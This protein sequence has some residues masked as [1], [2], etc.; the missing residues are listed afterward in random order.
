MKRAVTFIGGD[1]TLVA[2]RG[3]G[4][5]FSKRDQ[6]RYDSTGEAATSGSAIEALIVIEALIIWFARSSPKDQVAR[7]WA[8]W[9]S[10]W[11]YCSV[12][13]TLPRLPSGSISM[14]WGESNMPHARR[15]R[16]STLPVKLLP[17]IK[18]D[19]LV[20]QELE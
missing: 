13:L 4:R 20:L 10:A 3:I 17:L 18:L 16:L 8:H 12:M 1:H 19:S 14:G 6:Q 5:R 9:G 2:T 15:D 7:R 11:E